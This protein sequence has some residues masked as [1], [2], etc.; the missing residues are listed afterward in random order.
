MRMQGDRAELT[1]DMANPEH[2]RRDRSPH[3]AD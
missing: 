2:Q 1:R 3:F